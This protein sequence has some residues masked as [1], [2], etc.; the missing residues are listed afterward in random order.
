MLSDCRQ[1]GHLYL[2]GFRDDLAKDK[3]DTFRKKGD[4]FKVP[5][6]QVHTFK[7]NKEETTILVFRVYEKGKPIHVLIE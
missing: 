4:V 1:G 6:K 3:P 5:L 2:G 7:T